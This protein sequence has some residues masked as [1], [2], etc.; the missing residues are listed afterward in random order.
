[1]EKA[2]TANPDAIAVQLMNL[3]RQQHR[4]NV[5]LVLLCVAGLILAIEAVRESRNSRMAAD[6]FRL[7]DR[8]GRIRAVL[9]V[10]AQGPVLAF[11]DESGRPR[12]AIGIG[13][14]DG[15]GVVLADERGKPR[16]EFE[17]R[18]GVPRLALADAAGLVRA[19]LQLQSTGPVLGLSGGA[20]QIVDRDGKLVAKI[21]E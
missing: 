20:I 6:E 19:E 11:H 15:P 2:T 4:F 14:V 9:G 12:A 17:I 3:E 13:A 1:M 7:V 10:T 16:A 8:E 21:P 5:L 18:E